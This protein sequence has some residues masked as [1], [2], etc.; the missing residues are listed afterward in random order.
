MF[1]YRKRRLI[2]NKETVIKSGAYLDPQTYLAFV[3]NDGVSVDE[4]KGTVH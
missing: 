2:L 1:E 4:I 3:S